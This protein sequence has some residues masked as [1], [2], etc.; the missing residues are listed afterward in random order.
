MQSS[1]IMKVFSEN[2]RRHLKLRGATIQWLA[3]QSGIARPN[4]SRIL[5]GREN[6][7]L[8]RAEIIA[9][10][11]QVSLSELVSTPRNLVVSA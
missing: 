8:E 1:D 9:N 6:I 7:S 11:L 2:V 3:D 5:H 10:A 4:L